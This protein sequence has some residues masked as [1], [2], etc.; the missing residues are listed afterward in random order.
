M[1]PSLVDELI[2]RDAHERM[3]ASIPPAR[4]GQV[5]ELDAGHVVVA[6]RG[7]EVAAFLRGLLD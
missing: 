3:R 2:P 7:A 1:S 5:L 4:A 6:E